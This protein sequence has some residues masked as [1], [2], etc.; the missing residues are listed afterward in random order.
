M[1]DELLQYERWFEEAKRAIMRKA[2]RIVAEHGAQGSEPFYLTFR[3]DHPGVELSDSLRLRYPAEMTI[4]LRHTFWELEVRED[5]FS[6]V[7]SFKGERHRLVIPLEALLVFQ[8]RSLG[9]ALQFQN[10]VEPDLT[11]EPGDTAIS[12]NQV[13]TEEAG[14]EGGED[15]PAGGEDDKVVTLDKFRKK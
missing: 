9:F 13:Q 1:T 10:R 14:P 2:L 7:L 15:P 6:V 3:V 5:Y 12:G 4:D 8:D 11:K